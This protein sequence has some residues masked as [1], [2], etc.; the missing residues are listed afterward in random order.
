MFHTMQDLQENLLLEFRTIVQEEIDLEEMQGRGSALPYFDDGFGFGAGDGGGSY[1][2]G[3]DSTL[4]SGVAAAL[5]NVADGFLQSDGEAL[6]E[7]MASAAG[8]LIG[9]PGSDDAA[10]GAVDVGAIGGGS[11]AGAVPPLTAPPQRGGGAAEGEGGCR[12]AS[13]IAITHMRARRARENSTR[14]GRVALTG[15]PV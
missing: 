15:G 6:S 4:A 13:A 7:A 5:E 1:F 14:L 11:S 8:V 3:N 2:S 10:G 9:S 12:C